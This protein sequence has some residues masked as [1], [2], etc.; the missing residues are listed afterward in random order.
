[1]WF[2]RRYFDYAFE[3]RLAGVVLLRDLALVL[4]VAVLVLPIPLARRE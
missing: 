2:P 3:G 1:V 4:L